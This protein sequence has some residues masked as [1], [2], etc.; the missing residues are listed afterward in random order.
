LGKD[1][2]EL[3][4]IMDRAAFFDVMRDE[5][6]SLSQEQVEGTEALLNAAEEYQLPMNQLAYVLSTSWHETAATMMPIAEYGKGEGHDYG[7][8]CPEYGGQVAYGRGY[9]QLTWDYNYEKADNECELNHAL[10]DDFDLALDPIVASQIIFRGMLEGWFTGKKL[11]DYV[12][13][14]VTDY[15]NA[16]RVVNGTDKADMLAGYAESFEQA[17]RAAQYGAYD[18]PSEVTEPQPVDPDEITTPPEEGEH[19]PS[20]E[21]PALPVP[22]HKKYDYVVRRTNVDDFEAQLNE[23]GALGWRLVQMGGDI[24]IMERIRR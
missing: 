1:H 6:G 3:G 16:R 9:V 24:I 10:L 21:P 23:L 12:N 17:L 13:E 7:E 18:P 19:P 15:Y 20:V 22:K 8:P 5:F 11:G 4:Q 2:T 14:T